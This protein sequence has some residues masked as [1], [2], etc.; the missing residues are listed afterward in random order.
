MELLKVDI[1]DAG[2]SKEQ[3]IY[4]IHFS[5]NSGELKGLIGPNGSGKST[6]IKAIIGMLPHVN[7]EIVFYH[8]GKK[9]Y[10][11]IPEQPVF[12]DELTLWEHL[13]LAA[14]A[15]DLPSDTFK[16][17]ATE[18]LSLFHMDRLSTNSPSNFLKGCN[19]RS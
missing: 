14:A 13:E 2:Y 6:T 3:V 4:N 11:Y 12:Y 10:V 9:D 8:G 18:L 7:G 5:L 1:K 15:Y 19:R 17:R 16:K